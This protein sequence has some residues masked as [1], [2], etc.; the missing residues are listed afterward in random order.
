MNSSASLRS[1]YISDLSHCPSLP[2]MNKQMEEAVKSVSVNQRPP[3]VILFPFPLQGHIKPFM[4]LANVLSIRGFYITFVLTQFIQKRL[5]ECGVIMAHKDSMMGN[6]NHMN[7]TFETVPDGL[8]PQHGCSQNQN[9]PELC[10]S[11]AVNAHIHLSK[12]MEKL[13][14]LPNVPPVSFIVSD[15][16]L[17]K[18]QDTAD[19]YGV[20]RVAFWPTSAFGFTSFFSI[21]LLIDKGYLP[22][23]GT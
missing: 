20:P 11:M 3:H 21:P 1:F 10:E 15:G 9:L 2:F 22:L 4:N 6:K 19:E 16:L 8:P 12:L 23:K 14:H 7:I 5:A 13:R 18:I 17:S